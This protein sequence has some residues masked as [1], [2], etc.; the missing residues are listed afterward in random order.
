MPDTER[1]KL[2]VKNVHW[3]INAHDPQCVSTAQQLLEW[4]G[5]SRKLERILWAALKQRQEYLRVQAEERAL[6][7]KSR[8]KLPPRH[9]KGEGEREEI[10]DGA[11]RL[12]AKHDKKVLEANQYRDL[13]GLTQVIGFCPKCGDPTY[14]EPQR[15]CKKRKHEPVFYKECKTCSWWAEVWRHGNKFEEVEGG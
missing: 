14:G 7:K 6:R 8:Y 15:Q 13:P 5:E 9:I 3:Y 4:F 11:A 2:T 10:V 1:K 12:Y